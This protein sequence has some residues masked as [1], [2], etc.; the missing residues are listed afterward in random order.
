MPTTNKRKF[1]RRILVIA[2]SVFVFLLIVVYLMADSIVIPILKDRL[3]TLIIQGSDSLYTYRLGKLKANFFG[4]NVEVENLQVEVDSSRYQYLSERNQLPSLTMQLSLGSGKIS[5]IGILSL[6]LGKE[7]KINQIVSTDA[8]IR[9]TRHIRKRTEVH[10]TIP[11]WKAIRPKISSIS[12]NQIKLVGIKMH[13]KNIDTSESVKLQFDRFDANFKNIKIDSAA[14]VDTTRIGF[15]KEIEMKFREL[16]FRTEDSLYKMKAKEIDY[17]SVKRSLEIDSFKLQSTVEKNEFYT[18][19]G[20]QENMYYIEFDKV[21]FSNIR[22]DHFLY[23]NVI[24]ADSVVFDNPDID[25][26]N[27]RSYPLNYASKIGKYPHQE[28]L[29]ASSTI[30]INSVLVH[31]GQILYTEKNPETSQEGTFSISGLNMKARNIT[32]DSGQIRKNPVMTADVTGKILGASSLSSHFDFYLDSSDGRFSSSGSVKSLSADQLNKLAVP[33]GNVE[34]TSLQM[35]EMDYKVRGQDFQA[36]ADV[37]MRYSNLAL[38]LRKTDKETGAIKAKKFVTKIVNRFILWP[39][40]P[41]SDG[42]ERI[43]VNKTVSRLTTQAFFGL[44]WKTIFAG[45]EDIM[46]RSGRYE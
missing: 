33:L 41:G 8:D 46:M 21:K 24:D 4:G 39:S 30:M 11:I 6:L 32:N 14:S 17:S 35:Q 26:Y 27:D 2:L 44:I 15:T 19:K 25:I 43:A 42:K 1:L 34:L 29:K 12:I 37:R 23:N 28:L 22:L 18:K 13:Y 5:G 7:I 16:K 10:N 3:H 40:N 38:I 20:R 36:T 45:M 31:N 9:I